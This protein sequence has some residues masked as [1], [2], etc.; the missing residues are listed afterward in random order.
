MSFTIKLSKENFKFSGSHFTIFSNS[1]A[2][3]LHGHNY[4]VA[5]EIEVPQIDPKIGMAFDF[6]SVKPLVKAICESMDEKVLIPTLSPF[7]KV[8]SSGQQTNV[9]F[10]NKT[11]SL[12]TDDVELLAV[13][14]ITSEELSR[15]IAVRLKNE[16]Q[17]SSKAT[18]ILVDVQE[19]RGQS[20]SYKLKI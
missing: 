6:N 4:Y 20:V 10:A 11:Y 3:R 2:E 12:P 15:W 1:S 8:S 5:V 9:S 14:N 13:S 19:T 17:D 16:W 18:C 7:L